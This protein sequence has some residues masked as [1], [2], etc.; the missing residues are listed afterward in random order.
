MRRGTLVRPHPSKKCQFGQ[1][2]RFPLQLLLPPPLRHRLRP[3]AVKLQSLEAGH[4]LRLSFR[5]PP[6]FRIRTV[7]KPPAV[8]TPATIKESTTDEIGNN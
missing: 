4:K 7:R 5:A 1:D 3:R 6:R 2:L 8:V